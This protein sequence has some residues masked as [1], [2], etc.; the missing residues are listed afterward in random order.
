MISNHIRPLIKWSGSKW[1]LATRIIPLFPVHERYVELFAGTASVLLRKEPSAVE[2][3]NDAYAELINFYLIVINEHDAF[4]DKAKWFIS[5]E[6]LHEFYKNLEPNDNVERALKFFYL[7]WFSFV[8]WQGSRNFQVTRTTKTNRAIREDKFELFRKRMKDVQ[9][10]DRS[11]ETVIPDLD[12]LETFFFCDPPYYELGNRNYL[13]AFQHSDHAKL[14]LLL[15]GI[16]GKFLLTYNDCEEIRSLYSWA[17]FH[18]VVL[19]YHAGHKKDIVGR[20]QV[21]LIITN[22]NVETVELK[23][24]RNLNPI[25]I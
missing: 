9:L 3:L 13:L 17:N 18:A 8:G 19:T 1:N 5:C 10:L 2:I 22:Y 20:K 14:A 12:S 16:K 21:E 11:Y 7:N 4:M 23:S 6:K 24:M 15:K 25:Y